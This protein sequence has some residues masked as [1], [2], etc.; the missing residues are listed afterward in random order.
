MMQENLKQLKLSLEYYKQVFNTTVG[1]LE[2][3]VLVVNDK[4][5]I[6]Y[7]N[8]ASSELHNTD[9]IE[10]LSHNYTGS[11]YDFGMSDASRL[12]TNKDSPFALAVRGEK[13][14]NY[15]VI[16]TRESPPSKYVASYSATP[17]MVDGRFAH[18]VIIINNIRRL[19]P[20]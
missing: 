14:S 9:D 10:D 8:P 19:Q 18:S 2:D 17:F 13:F 1:M 11:N 5:D 15:D 4:G 6:V 7:Q 3:A 20:Y 16:V 12:L